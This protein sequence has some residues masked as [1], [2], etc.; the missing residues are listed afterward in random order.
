MFFPINRWKLINKE[1]VVGLTPFATREE[2][3]EAGRNS[4]AK[5]GD[6]TFVRVVQAS[7][8]SEAAAQLVVV[9]VP[10]RRST[11]KRV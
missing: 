3:E 5:Y 7:T 6:H 11:R 10:S 8:Y 9:S 1:L 2:A 4:A